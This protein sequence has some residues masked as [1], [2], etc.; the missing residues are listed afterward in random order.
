MQ[1]DRMSKELE[2]DLVVIGGGATGCG[3]AVDAVS[4]GLK[5]ALV[6]KDD[7][8]SGTS[9][10]STKLIHGGVRYLEKAM[11]QF[12]REQVRPSEKISSETSLQFSIPWS[13]K[14]WMNVEIFSKS[15][16]IFPDHYRSCYR[17]TGEYQ[18]EFVFSFTMNEASLPDGICYLIITQASKHMISCPV[19]NSFVDRI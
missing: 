1:I 10:R 7:F 4:R 15:L 5:V 17:F 11:L 14:H 2:Y 3:I 18:F 13:K 16:H 6:E 8:S 19:G 12:D 9:S